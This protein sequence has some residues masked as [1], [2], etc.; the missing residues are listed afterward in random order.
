[1]LEN[2]LAQVDLIQTTWPKTWFNIKTQLEQMTEHFI[3]YDRYKKMCEAEKIITAKTRETLVDFLNDLGVIL[4][5]KDFE[6]EDTHVLEP[7]WVTEAV[8][9]IINS[10]KL[11]RCKGV[12]NLKL[13]DHILQKKT[14]AD[15]DYP[16]NK[17]KYIITLMK[18]FELCYGMD[19]DTVLIPDLLEVQEPT[20][21]FNYDSSLKFILQ[22]DSL[23][24]SIMPR[25]IA[26]MHKNIK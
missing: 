3:S 21:D 11:T 18:K 1:M 24:R 16:R 6:L 7:K 26:N 12:L 15:Y 9:K 14:G 2:E 22:Y 23:P 10:E 5:F 20:F 17:Y 19:G 4:H 13:L 8:Y 25:S